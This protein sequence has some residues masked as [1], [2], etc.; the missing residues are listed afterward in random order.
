MSN[1]VFKEQK[2]EII[3]SKLDTNIKSINFSH[4]SMDNFFFVLR[5]KEVIHPHVLVG[6]PCYD[7]TPVTS[8]TLGSRLR[9]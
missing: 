1:S 6:I 5:R 3:L 2:R 4:R 7:F 8:P 9:G